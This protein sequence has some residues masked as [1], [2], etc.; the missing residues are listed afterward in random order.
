MNNYD[1]ETD[2]C[3]DE[4]DEFYYDDEEFIIGDYFYNEDDLEENDDEFEN[5]GSL[6]PSN[7][8]PKNPSQGDTLTP[9]RELVS[10]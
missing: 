6:V 10:A 9:E 3:D 5:G 2:Y 4:E 1:P 7:K 8:S